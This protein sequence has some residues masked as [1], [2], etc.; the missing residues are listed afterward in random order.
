MFLDFSYEYMEWGTQEKKKQ[1]CF[2]C[3]WTQESVTP[4]KSSCPDLSLPV[5]KEGNAH[6]A[7]LLALEH[8]G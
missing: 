7:V 5:Y 2:Q 1:A 8:T 6:R 4:Y 3:S